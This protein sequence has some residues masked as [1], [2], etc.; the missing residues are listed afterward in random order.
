MTKTVPIRF[1]QSEI[2]ME[3]RFRKRTQFTSA[4]Y[5]INITVRHKGQSQGDFPF[6]FKLWLETH[7]PHVCI[8]VVFIMPNVAKKKERGRKYLSR[9]SNNS[10]GFRRRVSFE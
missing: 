10:P 4:L 1:E 8:C 7:F 2:G 6:A 5:Q 9:K 3:V